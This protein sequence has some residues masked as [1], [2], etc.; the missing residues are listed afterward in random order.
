MKVATG[1]IV[2]LFGQ[3][4]LFSL[5]YIIESKFVFLLFFATR[6]LTY[7]FFRSFFLCFFHSCMHSFMHSYIARGVQFVGKPLGQVV[8]YFCIHSDVYSPFDSCLRDREYFLANM[9][10]HDL[11]TKHLNTRGIL[12]H[13]HIRI[14]SWFL[15][16]LVMSPG[17][18]DTHFPCGAPGTSY[19]CPSDPGGT[20]RS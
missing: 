6:S 5:I 20:R 16:T 10:F 14:V 8:T 1:W 15:V 3:G 11:K 12:T 19:H 4:G 2:E 18:L 17:F 13:I 7:S 9:Q